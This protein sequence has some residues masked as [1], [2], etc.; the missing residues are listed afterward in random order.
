MFYALPDTIKWKGVIKNKID[1]YRGALLSFIGVRNREFLEGGWEMDRGK[2]RARRE[3]SRR[4]RN[5]QEVGD[6]S[7]VFANK[8][9]VY[10]L[11]TRKESAGY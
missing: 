7:L 4:I 3:S 8:F 1:S 9:G 10:H 6:F 11:H 2:E 5:K